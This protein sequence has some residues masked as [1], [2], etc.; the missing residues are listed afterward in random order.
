MANVEERLAKLETE[1]EELKRAQSESRDLSAKKI[2]WIKKITGRFEND[3][4]FDEMLRL[5]RE[6][7][8]SNILNDK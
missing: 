8:Q 1:F 7:R 2:E 3:P 4:E 6:Q 5:G